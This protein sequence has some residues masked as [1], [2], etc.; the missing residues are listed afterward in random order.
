MSSSLVTALDEIGGGGDPVVSVA[1]VTLSARGRAVPLEVRVS[2]PA[3][4]GDL[5]VVVFSHGNGWNLDGYAPLTAFWASRGFVVVQPTHLDSRRNGFGFDHP[6][7]PSIWTERIAD[8]T[9]V[10][11]QLDTIEAAVPGL[12]GRVDRDRIAATGHSWGGQTAQAFLG[13]RIVDEEGH[14]GGDMSDS[15]VTAGILFAATGLGGDDLHPFAKANFPFMRPSFAELSTP[16]L[17]VA[18]DHDQS[19]MSSRGPDWFT[20]AYTH[21]PGATD[22]LTLHGAEHALGGIVGYEVAETTDENPER[23]AVVQRMSAAYLRTALHVD[24]GAWPSARNALRR[25]AD[26]IGYIDTK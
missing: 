4:G 12:A 1:P 8:L 6:V 11:D 20:D 24:E 13:A 17:V 10:L 9:R 5:P 21:S 7:F 16:T 14:V 22:L 18:G 23:V 26:P 15:R 25:A 3:T 2:A 19:K